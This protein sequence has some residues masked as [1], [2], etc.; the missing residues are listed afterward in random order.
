M[1]QLDKNLIH[2]AINPKETRKQ[3]IEDFEEYEEIYNKAIRDAERLYKQEIAKLSKNVNEV[4]VFL[5]K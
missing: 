5:D 3:V 4:S 2:K 1:K